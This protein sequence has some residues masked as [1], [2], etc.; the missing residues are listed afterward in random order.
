MPSEKALGGERGLI[1][2]RRVQHHLDDAFHIAI[3]RG[4]GADV[5]AKPSG[6]G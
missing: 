4:Q 1:V 5:D 2:P 3:G 6:E